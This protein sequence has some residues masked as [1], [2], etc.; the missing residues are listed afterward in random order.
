[1]APSKRTRS[2]SGLGEESV[3]KTAKAGA[4]EAVVVPPSEPRPDPCPHC[5][6]DLDGGDIYEQLREARKRF[7]PHIKRFHA[8]MESMEPPI[9]GDRDLISASHYGWS[10]T[11]RKRFSKRTIVQHEDRPQ[12]VVCPACRKVLLPQNSS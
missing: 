7:P 12:E 8:M 5:S 9:T 6:Y 3:A 10:L 11:N 4:P 2:L 1:M